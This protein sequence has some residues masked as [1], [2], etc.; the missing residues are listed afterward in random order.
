MSAV[1]PKAVQV[2][3]AMALSRVSARARVSF[4]IVRM[5]P[6][7]VT[8]SGITLNALD[9]LSMEQ[10]DTTICWIGSALRDAMLC[11]ADTMVEA[12]TI[13]STVRLGCAA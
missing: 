7:M 12:V 6:L 1:A 9:E 3:V 4:D 13:G 10:T 2:E 5:V 8:A 11:S